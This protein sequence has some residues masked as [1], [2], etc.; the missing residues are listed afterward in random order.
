MEMLAEG[1]TNNHSSEVTL[2]DQTKINSFSKLISRKDLLTQT[3]SI[4]KQDKEYLD[5][6]AIEIEMLDDEGGN[7]VK[8]NYKM[9]DTFIL[10]K[11]DAVIERVEE[12][13]ATVD[14]KI[15]EI[16]S[17]IETIDGELEELKKYLYAK[18]G[19]SINLER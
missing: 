14:S 10:M 4:Q 7:E 8:I 11:K 16:E 12:D 2:S 5:D 1:Q 13:L 19:D 9:G 17:K 3:L 18:F 6:L 15:E